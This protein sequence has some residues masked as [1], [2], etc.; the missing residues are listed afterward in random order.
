MQLQYLQSQVIV[1]LISYPIICQRQ[2]NKKAA[3]AVWSSSTELLV[4]STRLKALWLTR[5][6]KHTGLLSLLFE[7]ALWHPE[8]DNRSTCLILNM[9]HCLCICSRHWATQ[10]T[11][12]LVFRV[13][14]LE[15]KEV[16][17][18]GR[19]RHILRWLNWRISS[20]FGFKWTIHDTDP[21]SDEVFLFLNA[22]SV[23]R[24]MVVTISKIPP[25]C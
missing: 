6:M 22:H 15:L 14:K 2:I 5:W 1:I 7:L 3:V 16:I 11:P 20:S 19:L 9:K 4:W 12:Y 25:G 13:I 18:S 24:N 17:I 10:M 8:S 23:I 21:S